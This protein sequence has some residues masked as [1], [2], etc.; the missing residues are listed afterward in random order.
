VAH[1]WVKAKYATDKTTG[2]YRS[3]HN[4]G[5]RRVAPRRKLKDRERAA[6]QARQPHVTLVLLPSGKRRFVREP[7]KET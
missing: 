3:S 4:D 7:R 5:K 1:T 2:G 6:A